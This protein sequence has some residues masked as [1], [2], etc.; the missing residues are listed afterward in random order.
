M[1]WYDK[2]DPTKWGK[3]AKKE[4]EKP[5]KEIKSFF[6]D[7]EKDLKSLVRKAEH[8]AR[9]AVGKVEDVGEEI[10][11]GFKKAGK[12]IEDGIRK[13]GKE[14]EEGVVEKI[15]ELV[16]EA[17]PDAIAK[18]LKEL[19][20][21]AIKPAL[22][23]AAQEAREF[24]HEM[25]KLSEEDP[26]LVGAIGAVGFGVEIKANVKLGLSY[27]GFYGRAR[28]VAG[29]LDR[30][31]HSGI[32]LRRRDIIGF[33]EAV[34]PDTV[35]F[36][37]GAEISLGVNLGASFSMSSIPLKLFTRLGDRALKRLGVPE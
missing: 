9:K 25:D 35:D 14:V 7:A 12:E 2:L 8:E 36:G 3:K 6:S 33:V 26:E 10:E 16:T 21:E 18:A 27:S 30:Y 19:A 37:V 5:F 32:K 24:A 22:K 17:L 1:A 29:I 23:K 11:K 4:L 28:E 31:G 34:G 20:N 13:A 15:P